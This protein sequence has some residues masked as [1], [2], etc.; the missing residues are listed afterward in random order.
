MSPNS[1]P[2]MSAVD[3]GTGSE[4][5]MSAVTGSSKNCC[6]A[7]PWL[8]RYGKTVTTYFQYGIASGWPAVS[9]NEEGM[10][11]VVYEQPVY[12]CKGNCQLHRM[13][14]IPSSTTHFSYGLVLACGLKPGAC[15][16]Q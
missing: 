3:I 16:I 14:C 10:L 7:V 2:L 15:S 1:S 5:K 4:C 13:Q 6:T 9:D 8:G 12:R 11:C